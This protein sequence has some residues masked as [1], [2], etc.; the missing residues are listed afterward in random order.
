MN[1]TAGLLVLAFATAIVGAFLFAW[2]SLTNAPSVDDGSFATDR[3]HATLQELLAEQVPHPTGSAENRRVRDRILAQFRAAGYQPEVQSAFQCAPPD[4]APGCTQ[5]ENIIAVLKGTGEGR[6]I[7]ATAHY[8]SVPAGPG[9]G[10]DGVG[11]VVML[12]LARTLKAMPPARNDIIFLI[13]DGE[14]TGLRGA[15]A[16]A[17]NH[18]LMQQVGIVVNVEARGN[19]GPA[20]M[21]ETGSG[22]SKLISLFADSVGSQVSNSLAY[23][24]YRLLPNDTDFT[25]YKNA[26]LNGYNF[27][28]I[29]GAARYHTPK[30]NLA[31]LDRNSLRHHGQQ[32][33]A[34]VRAL[35]GQD[36]ETLRSQEDASYFDLF[37]KGLVHWP[38]ALNLP[39]A[40]AGLVLLA[41][42][43]MTGRVALSL[44]GAIWSM[45]SLLLLPFAMF[46]MGWVL[47]YPLGIWPEV[48]ILDHQAPWPARV[49]LLAASFTVATI[50][51]RLLEPRAK[52]QAV[53][54]VYWLVLSLFALASAAALPG[55]AYAF[56]WPVVIFA[57]VAGLGQFIAPGP[58]I[59]WASVA[60]F[61]AIAM[62][63]TG[64]MLAL[65]AVVGFPLSQFKLLA[66]LPMTMALVPLFM[67]GGPIRDT[68]IAIPVGLTVAA[69]A[70]ASTMPGYTPDN[71][72]PLNIVYHQD[73][74]T[75]EAR[76]LVQ[77]TPVDRS[78]IQRAGFA[79]SPEAFDLAGL[80]PTQAF[81]RKATSARLEAPRLNLLSRE[82][83]ADRFVLTG[84][85][86]SVRAGFMFGLVIPAGSGI[87]AVT[88]EGQTLVTPERLS[89]SRPVWARIFGTADKPLSITIEHGKQADGR[90][91]L[92]ERSAL[93]DTPEAR[94]LLASRPAN[95][96]PGHAGD[97]AF[98]FRTLDLRTLTPSGQVA[99]QP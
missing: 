82:Q 86:S 90:I 92:F 95:A 6:A 31:L 13:T 14:E 51:A 46:A 98:V 40:F 28:M 76:W 85:V 2:Q 53:S 39:I 93:P 79:A 20:I 61:V 16:F 30:D 96:S 70:F 35:Q 81:T 36:L 55:A 21:F 99:P 50:A 10:D 91:V 66:L 80:V 18:A 74:E 88:L 15:V 72:R 9:V 97:G 75:G 73:A 67:G 43:V 58:A 5:V 8:D 12:E 52:P 23:E 25:I 17:Q 63:W 38:A 59:R 69:A 57:L 84:T 24:I 7:L 48:H 27:A 19:T 89:G 33:T 32:V 77:E 62:F 29:G 4:K 44:A 68:V 83:R 41:G 49:A 78:F 54:L 42:M 26:G 45:A 47:S 87:T 56:L 64:H 71:P 65:D 94:T 37:G 60:G 3:A 22:N 11:V 34:L 1:R